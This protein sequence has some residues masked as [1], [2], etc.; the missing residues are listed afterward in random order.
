[1]A[2][3]TDGSRGY[4]LD[5]VGS[6]APGYYINIFQVRFDPLGERLMTLTAGSG[7]S[8][9]DLRKKYEISGL[10]VRF[11]FS[12]KTKTTYAYGPDRDVV[13]ADGFIASTL[14]LPGVPDLARRLMLDG[15]VDHLGRTG[16]KLEWAMGR[17]TAVQPTAHWKSGDGRV[18]L[19][20]GFDINSI[21]WSD[22][23]TSELSFGLVV[24]LK[25]VTRDG[26]GA[27]IR[28]AAIAATG[29]SLDVARAQGELLPG[30]ARI[31]TEV[32]RLH[33]EESILP[34]VRDSLMVKLGGG[35]GLVVDPVPVRVVVGAGV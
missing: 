8:V 27:T 17:Y 33:L 4:F 10:S 3:Y 30:S 18:Q 29:L 7:P 25:W 11:H 32:A 24:D 9:K 21:M 6:R 22:P 26:A 13:S 34:F 12:A 15:Y 20:K 16:Y 1:M 5:G 35:G 2:E 14:E 28:P 19:F 31:N 23:R